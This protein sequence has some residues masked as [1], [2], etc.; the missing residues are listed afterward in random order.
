MAWG[1]GTTQGYAEIRIEAEDYDG[2][3]WKAVYTVQTT[4][5]DTTVLTNTMIDNFL[6][7]WEACSN[8]AIVK[9]ELNSVA[10]TPFT[11]SAPKTA[12]NALQ[13]LV[14]A[15]A[16]LAFERANPLIPSKT[17]KRTVGIPAFV[18]GVVNNAG[19]NVYKIPGDTTTPGFN[20]L[21]GFLDNYLAFKYAGNDLYYGGL[22]WANADSA[23]VTLP[24][25]I[26]PST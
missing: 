5:N 6:T 1:A 4:G 10:H 25:E 14:G 15:V 17:I 19:T 13:S 18:D 3:E 20:R 11:N 21:I 23:F 26:E 7:D 9:A 8:A 2:E 22:A 12:V 24:R 16:E